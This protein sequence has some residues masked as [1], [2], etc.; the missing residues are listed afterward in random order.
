MKLRLTRKCLK[1]LRQYTPAELC[2]VI[3]WDNGSTD[4]T[5]GF[6][7]Q[8]PASDD[9]LRYFRSEENLGFI[10]GNNAAARHAR[11]RFL[12]FLNNDTEPQ[13]GW[14]EA[15]LETVEADPGV[16][17]V[18]AKLIYPNG[19]LQEAGGIIFER[20]R[21]ELRANGGPSRAA[22][23]FSTRSGLLLRGLS[24]GARRAVSPT[25]RLRPAL[26]ARFTTRG[27]RSMLR[28]APGGLQSPLPAPLR[29]HPPR[30]ARPRSGLEPAVSNSI[31]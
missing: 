24:S 29:N 4:G 16:G 21:V 20:F 28:V 23:Q 14:L 17:A 31:R 5:R 12:V 7:Q 8:Q 13:A 15:L 30:K 22:L 18:G 25:G 2:E 1:A 11:G 27:R 19:K 10:G 6:F 26:R 3:V 9:A